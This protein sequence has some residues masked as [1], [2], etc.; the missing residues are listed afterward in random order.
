MDGNNRWATER[1]L[2]GTAGHEVGVERVRDVLDACQR[3]DIGKFAR[4]F[5]QLNVFPELVP[6]LADKFYACRHDSL[7]F[8]LWNARLRG[9]CKAQNWSYNFV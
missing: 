8:W 6:P 2:S 7:G 5:Q 1:G 4:G 9:E 3:H